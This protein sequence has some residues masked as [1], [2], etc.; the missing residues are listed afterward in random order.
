[1]CGAKAGARSRSADGSQE[2]RRDGKGKGESEGIPVL[3]TASSAEE[4]PC[5]GDCAAL[6]DDAP[7][8]HDQPTVTKSAATPHLT[9]RK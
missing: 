5:L 8:Q 3:S 4:P 2:G 9:G 7:V 6:V 1:M